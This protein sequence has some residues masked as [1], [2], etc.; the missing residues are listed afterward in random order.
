MNNKWFKLKYIGESF[1]I[2]ELTNGKVYCAIEDGKDMYRVVDD[3]DEDYLYDKINPRPTD[4]SS[5]G[6]KWEIVDTLKCRDLDKKLKYISEIDYELNESITAEKL[7]NYI[8][9]V[10]VADKNKIVEYLYKGKIELMRSNVR[11]DIIDSEAGTIGA[12]I[13]RTDGVYKWSS[14]LIYYFVNYNLKL[15]DEFLDYIK[16]NK[17]SG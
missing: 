8:S 9:K 10:P 1:G 5:K 15:L 4:D 14:S 2:D 6:G 3:S 12:E 17:K 13:W 7:K 16:N 11:N